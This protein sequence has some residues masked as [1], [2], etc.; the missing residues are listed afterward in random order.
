MF[1]ASKRITAVHRMLCSIVA[2]C[3]FVVISHCSSQRV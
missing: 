3:G 1:V 2:S